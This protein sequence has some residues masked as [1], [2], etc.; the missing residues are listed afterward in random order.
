MARS[1]GFEPAI[2]GIEDRCLIQLGYERVLVARI[3]RRAGKRGLGA[4]FHRPSG[5]D[6]SPCFSRVRVGADGHTLVAETG[7]TGIIAIW[8]FGLGCGRSTC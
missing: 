4:P 3:T 8:V 6:G 5:F 2:C 7:S 1:A